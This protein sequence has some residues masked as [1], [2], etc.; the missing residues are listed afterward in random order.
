M[1]NYDVSIRYKH[2]HIKLVAL[3]PI[4]RSSDTLPPD[5]VYNEQRKGVQKVIELAFGVSGCPSRVLFPN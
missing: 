2:E 5:K 1:L 3:V 4:L